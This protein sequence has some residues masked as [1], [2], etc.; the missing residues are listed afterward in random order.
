MTN[1]CNLSVNVGVLSYQKKELEHGDEF[2]IVYKKNEEDVSKYL[3]MFIILK[4]NVK[5]TS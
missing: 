2:Y 1:Q 4:I 5:F 3:F